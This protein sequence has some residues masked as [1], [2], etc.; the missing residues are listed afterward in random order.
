MAAS[1]LAFGVFLAHFSE[2]RLIQVVQGAALTTML[3]NLLAL[4][5]QEARDPSR[6]AIEHKRASFGE[7][8]RAFTAGTAIA[9]AADRGRAR[10][11][12]LQHAGHPARTLWRADP[13]SDRRADDLADRDLG[14]RR[15]CRLCHRRLEPR[16]RHRL[17][18]G[19]G[20]RRGCRAGGVLRGDFRRPAGLGGAVRDR[21]QPDRLWRRPLR[22]R[23]A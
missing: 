5:K 14:G 1:A 8:W 3:L 16:P 4:W 12:R 17:L 19:C 2:M 15:S 21:R 6:T 23:H 20:V 9:P 10:H 11:R 13:S 7:A 18:S 22:G